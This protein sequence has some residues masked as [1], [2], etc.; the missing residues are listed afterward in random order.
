[1]RKR[2]RRNNGNRKRKLNKQKIFAFVSFVF[3]IVCI[4]W[5]GGRAVYF[6]LDSKKTLEKENTTL[7]R[8]IIS[9]NVGS[10]NFKRINGVY[11]FQKDAKANYLMYSNI[12]WR[13]IKVTKDNNIV[14]ISDDTITN[15]AFG[16]NKKY[17]NSYLMKWLNKDSDKYTGIMENNLNN[18]NNYLV[19]TEACVDNVTNIKKVTCK[20]INKKN[21]LSLLYI[22]DY[23]NTGAENS[24]INNNKYTYLAN[25]KNDKVWYIDEDGK[26]SSNSGEEIYGVKPVITLKKNIKAVSGDGTE[27][28]P[29]VIENEKNKFG[30]YVKLDEDIWRVYDEDDTYIKLSLNDYLKVDDEKFEYKY[31]NTNYYHNDTTY[32][33]LAYYLNHTY[34]YKLSYNNLI[35]SSK[36]HNYYYGEDNNYDYSSVLNSTVDTKV[37]L[38]SIADPIINNNLDN[39]FILSGP[40][41]ESEEVYI[42]SKNSTIDSTYS[43]DTAYVIPT[44]TIEKESLK[45]GSGTETDPYRTE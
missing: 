12:L 5:Y 45:S 32:G 19:K 28:S 42:M 17:S 3:I 39:Y 11:Y 16:K 14:L 43:T 40:G 29:Y 33:T 41:K 6:Y 18:M 38:L 35:V 26:L 21:Y 22:T 44:I 10:A 15:L 27:A 30:S 20:N 34:L 31:S 36:Y 8:N 7:A 9:A 13:V 24:F 1:M 23:I 2:R 37:G 4:F 25:N